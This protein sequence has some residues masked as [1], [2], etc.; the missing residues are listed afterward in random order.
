MNSERWATALEIIARLQVYVDE[1]DFLLG[2]FSA[3]AGLIFVIIGLRRLSLRCEQGPQ[4][5]GWAGPVSWMM[6]GIMFWAA[7]TFIDV[8]SRTLLAG[9]ANTDVQSVFTS[10]PDLLRIFEG[11]ASQETI[12]GLLR[13]VQLFGAVA[14]LRGLFILNSSMQPTGGAAT[15]GSGT[16]HLIG[17]TLAINIV[18][19]L[20]MLDRLVA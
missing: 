2:A 13:L 9:G 11:H 7:P 1:F 20:S 3:L 12:L 5:G 10:A 15:F 4:G 19:V 18:A 16:T 17:G 6:I 8:L 14:I